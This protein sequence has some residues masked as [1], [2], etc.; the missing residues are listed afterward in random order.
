MVLKEMSS[1]SRND[2]Y[3]GE[4]NCLEKTVENKSKGRTSIY[5]KARSYLQPTVESVVVIDDDKKT[6]LNREEEQNQ[7]K[8]HNMSREY[9]IRQST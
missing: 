1:P 2:I 6:L 9:L 8:L 7:T 4:A 3:D 5:C